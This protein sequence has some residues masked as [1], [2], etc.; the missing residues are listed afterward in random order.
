MQSF[1]I[2]VLEGPTL[3]VCSSLASFYGCEKPLNPSAM[4]ITKSGKSQRS[5]H[6]SQ[7]AE[8]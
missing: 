2:K 8:L 6:P 4:A 5:L 1:S 7:E 3:F